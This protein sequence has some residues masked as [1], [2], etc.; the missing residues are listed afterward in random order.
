MKISIVTAVYN[1]EKTIANTMDSVLMQ[2]YKDFEHIIVDGKSSDK[3][4][5]IVKA[6]EDKYEGKLRYISEKD[7]G[8][9][10][11]INKGVKMATGDVVGILNSD[12]MYADDAVLTHISEAFI[13]DSIDCIYGNYDLVDPDNL[14]KCLRKGRPGEYKERHFFKGW[15]PPHPTFYAKTELYRKHGYYLE[16][17]KIAA[18]YE[19][20][21]RFFVKHNIKSAYVN[22]TL[23]KM[24]KGGVSTNL[25]GYIKSNMEV[26]KSY[27]INEIRYPLLCVPRKVLPKLVQ[28]MFSRLKRK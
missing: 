4:M 19:L 18:D 1:R 10:N 2:K 5:E 3:T 23:I 26:I 24:R 28:E 21:L 27:K 11:A 13:N 14:D 17:M 22:E 15:H 16:T 6:Y 20:M 25:R 12:D 8:I 7:T 9:Y